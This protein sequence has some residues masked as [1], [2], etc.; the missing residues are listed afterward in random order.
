MSAAAKGSEIWATMPHSSGD[1]GGDHA[2]LSPLLAPSAALAVPRQVSQA[3]AFL[4]GLLGLLAGP[5][6]P[7]GGRTGLVPALL[8]TV[9]LRGGDWLCPKIL[10]LQTHSLL[11]L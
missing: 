9:L 11:F 2:Q 10:K 8:V 1:R 5:S 7:S 6:G 3:P 4:P